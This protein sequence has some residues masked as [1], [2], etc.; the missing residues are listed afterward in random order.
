M[1][2]L[3]I[4]HSNDVDVDVY[5]VVVVFK[6]GSNGQIPS[7]SARLP[8]ALLPTVL[9]DVRHMGLLLAGARGVLEERHLDVI[10]RFFF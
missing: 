9:S 3:Y 7:Q 2:L 1:I 10:R 4:C 6:A 8:F 5:V